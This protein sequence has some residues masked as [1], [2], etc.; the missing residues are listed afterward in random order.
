MY[1]IENTYKEIYPNEQTENYKNRV[2]LLNPNTPGNLSLHISALTTEDQGHY[3]CF[4]SSQQVVGFILTVLHAEGCDLVENR[5]TVVVT[6]YS[7]ESVALPCSCTELLAKP[8]Q[9][10]WMYLIENTYK[11]IY[12]NEQTE[13]YKN[14]VK[15]LNPN[16]PG[17]LSLH[18]SALTTEDQGHY[19]CFVS[20]Q[21][22]VSFRLTVLH[23]EGCDLVENR[24]TVVV[25][26][27]SGE[28]VALPCSCTELLAKPQQIQ[29]MYLIENT[30]KEIYP[31][32]QTENY[33]NRVKLLNP[34]TP[35]NLSLHISALT[36]EDQGHYQ[37]MTEPNIITYVDLKG[38]GCDLVE[39][40]RTVVVTGYSGESVVLPC[41]CTELLAKPQQIQWMY[42]IENTYKEI[43]P[44]EQTENYKNR[45]KL[46]NPNTPGNL[47]LHISALTTEDQGHYQCFVSSQQVVSFRLTVLHAEG[48]DL[49]ENRRTVV[50]TG[51]SGESVVLPCSCTELLAKP[52]QIQWMYLIENTYKEIY[53][54]EQ[55]ENYKNRVKLLNP[56]TPGNLSLHIS[57]LT[58]EDQ[59]HYQC[60][61]S[62]QKV[63]SFRLTVLHAEGC[64][65]VENRRTVVV[66][67]YSGESVVLPCSCTEL[68]AK[69]QQIQWMYLIENTYKEIY[70]NEQTENYKNRVKLL[71]PNTPGNL[72]LHISA[73]TTEDQGHYQCFVSSQQDEVACS[74]VVYVETT[75]PPAH[76]QNDPVELPNTKIKQT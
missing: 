16:T 31:N 14:R 3:Q 1:L 13:N 43:Y 36:T 76:A 42:L 61:V 15:L 49:V 65:L 51:Y 22:V 66:T 64:D 35:G 32:E 68:L 12:P 6:G 2:K 45:V 4:V 25:T 56:N 21:Q 63:V 58:T 37:C 60:F 18:I 7:G 27:Y 40:R 73:L 74:D 52:Q 8:Q 28:S 5:R 19:Q 10:Q 53:P 62:S 47:S 24:R 44:N 30:Y 29:W 70:P 34:N 46:L 11:E 26:G 55:T 69:P 75:S 71:N 17:N 50:V 54:N 48:C 57:A 33:K 39:N 20:S 59:G 72:S 23:A 38:K 41:S 67:G 9:I